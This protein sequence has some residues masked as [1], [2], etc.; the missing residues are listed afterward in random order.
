VLYARPSEDVLGA[1]DPGIYFATGVAI[2]RGGGIV[3]NDPALRALA[4]NLGDASI[5]YWLFQSVHGWPLRFPGQLF[6]RDLPSGEVEPGFLPW[7]PVAVA[8]TVAAGGTEA[9][10]WV[11]PALAVLG[12]V[13]VYLAGRALLGPLP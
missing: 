11:N 3:Q 12:L 4:E 2:A 9:G 7:Y 8:S 6:V 13:A 1:R 5:N 10:L